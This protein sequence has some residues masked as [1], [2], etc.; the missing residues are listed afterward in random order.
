MP[1]FVE[2][3]DEVVRVASRSQP[4]P[5]DVPGRTRWAA[6]I[7]PIQDEGFDYEFDPRRPRRVSLESLRAK[8]GVNSVDQEPQNDG[9]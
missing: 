2:S 3:L 1:D 9:L 6:P 4:P 8:N 7:G 5:C